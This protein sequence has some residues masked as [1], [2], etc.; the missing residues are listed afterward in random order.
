MAI[1]IVSRGRS[2][3]SS[4]WSRGRSI[5]GRRLAVLATFVLVTIGGGLLALSRSPLLAVRTID[6]RGV[7][8]LSPDRVR[9]L[10]D[11]DPGADL[12]WLDLP[13]VEARIEQGRWVADAS[14]DRELPSTLAIRIAERVPVALVRTSAGDTVVAGDGTLL[15]HARRGLRLPRLD[16][17]AAQLGREDVAPSELSSL[18]RVARWLPDAVRARVE[19]LGLRGD[20]SVLLTI[21]GG[22]EVSFGSVDDLRAKGEALGEVLS[23]MR[24]HHLDVDEISLVSPAAPAVS[25]SA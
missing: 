19:T 22:P 14:V 13:A 23:W 10:A 18:A 15:G 12:L 16:L 4:L 3:W 8:R 25:L 17:H 21:A 9:G 1:W 24:R 20:G 6:V 11:V 7:E 5:G 2:V